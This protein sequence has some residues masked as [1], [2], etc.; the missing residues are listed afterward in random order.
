[1]SEEGIPK[2][3]EKIGIYVPTDLKEETYME[4]YDDVTYTQYMETAFIPKMKDIKQN[5]SWGSTRERQFC[6]HKQKLDF[7]ANFIQ[8]QENWVTPFL[9]FVKKIFIYLSDWERQYTR[10]LQE[11]SFSVEE[12]KRK[13]KIPERIVNSF[14]NIAIE[15]HYMF[16]REEGPGIYKDEKSYDQ[17][18][19]EVLTT[20]MEECSS[21]L[22]E[23]IK[24]DIQKKSISVTLRNLLR[25]FKLLDHLQL[26]KTMEWFTLLKEIV[27]RDF[28]PTPVLALSSTRSTARKKQGKK[29]GE[30]ENP[31]EY[32][33]EFFTRV[34]D[35]DKLA[36]KD[37]ELKN[38]L[39]IKELRG[40]VEVIKE[41]LAELRE[42]DEIQVEE[43]QKIIEENVVRKY[44]TSEELTEF[45]QNMLKEL[46][47]FE[48][49][50]LKKVF[51]R[52]G[53]TATE[54][55]TNIDAIIQEKVP[56][57]LKTIEEGIADIKQGQHVLSKETA[58]IQAFL[59]QQFT[60]V[61]DNQ[62]TI[63]TYLRRKLGSDF[64]KI[65]HLWN[66][67]KE[68][69]ITGRVFIKEATKILGSKFTKV[70]LDI[71]LFFK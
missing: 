66:Q 56:T 67:Y 24:Y 4:I 42:G 21:L 47:D 7:F 71:L 6:E 50:R 46:S 36:E 68:K 70:F 29:V 61:I 32:F 65:K 69:K 11:D 14:L 33:D 45:F 62:E 58:E 12:Y 27:G 26:Q 31:S 38:Y 60:V 48:Y 51:R 64:E 49:V 34:I 1:M 37:T 30:M 18:S 16:T 25:N 19:L 10:D 8:E 57:S 22:M 63:E 39:R 9:T 13:Q 3:E 35:I 44:F 43:A 55:L 5:C 53:S 59:E 23:L 41:L 15:V 54:L 40:I 17:E 52:R 20:F 28:Q 2:L